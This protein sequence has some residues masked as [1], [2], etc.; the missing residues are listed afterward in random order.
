MDVF[1]K[2]LSDIDN[3]QH[4]D[5]IGEVLNWVTAKYP[6]LSPKIGWNQPMFT[7]HGTFIIGFSA[8]RKHFA[9]A[10][11]TAGITRFSDEII[12]AGYDHTKGL[13]RIPWD[14]PVDYPL[15]EKI[16]EFNIQD[17]ADC[18]TFWRK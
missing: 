5:R 7:D 12:E 13:I 17:K 1:G 15:L 14:S 10:P 2:Y 4:R 8:A 3:P 18:E 6:N 9:V 11:E 16:I